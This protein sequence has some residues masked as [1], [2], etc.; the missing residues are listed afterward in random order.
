MEKFVVASGM[1]PYDH[2]THEG[3]WRQLTARLGAATDQLMIVAAL[4]PQNLS[5]TELA[6]VKSDLIAFFSIGEGSSSK[7][8]SLYFQTMGARQVN[9]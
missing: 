5:E 3:F 4:H 1:E 2:E 8:H 7:I 6:K 9:P